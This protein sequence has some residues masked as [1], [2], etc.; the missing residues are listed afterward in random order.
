[1]ANKKKKKN[2]VNEGAPASTVASSKAEAKKAAPSKQDAPAKK[3][4]KPKNE[5]PGLFATTRNRL[6]SVR[7]EMK[8]VVWPD[9]KELINYSVAV[10]AS[11]I[12]VGIA[13][14]LIDFVVGEGLVLF[15]GLRG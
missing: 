15:S 11:L 6:R 10:C 1:M 4:K 14:A 2:V 7:T 12:V 5:K 3:T 8:R 13:I 9:K